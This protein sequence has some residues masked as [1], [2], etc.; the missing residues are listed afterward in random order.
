MEGEGG[1][2]SEGPQQA[3]SA[4]RTRGAASPKRTGYVAKGDDDDSSA[5]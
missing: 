3:Q 2:I 4:K 5:A 1:A